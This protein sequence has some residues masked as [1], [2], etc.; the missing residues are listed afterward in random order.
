MEFWLFGEVQLRAGEQVLDVGT[1][2]QQAVLAALAVD[3][4]RPVAMETLVDRVWHDA[5]P[6]EAR[7]VLYSHL[8]R[9]RQLLRRAEAVTGTTARLDRRTS[10]YVLAVDPG[11]IDLHRFA[12]LV[13]RGG[14]QARSIEERADSLAEA[15]RLWRG[16]P[17]AGIQ[18]EWAAQVRDTWH[19]RRL[20]AAVRWASLQLELERAD[21][22][23]A[24][25]PGLV[26]E[27]PLA[28]PLEVL[29]LRALHA[30]GRDAEALDRYATVQQRLAEELGTDPGPELRTLHGALL[31]GELPVAERRERLATPA[32]LPPDVYGFAGRDEE[33]RRLD[34]VVAAGARIVAMSGTAGVGKTSLVVHWAHRVRDDFPGGQLYV[35]LRGFDPTGSPVPPAVAVRGFLDAFEVPLQR[36]PATFE[37]Q[38]GLYR[39]LLADRHVLV[40][41]DNARDAEQVRQLLPGSPT[42]V[43]LVASRNALVGLVTA[44]AHPLTVDLLT[45]DGARQL[46]VGRLGTAR[47][48]A[49]PRAVDEIIGLCARLP[50]ALAVVAARAATNP[51]FDLAALARELGDARYSLDE[52]A[53]ADPATDPRAVFSWS[54][55][56]LT[57][58]A[59]RLFRLFGLNSG[60]EIGARATASLMGL[61]PAQVRQLLAE[62]VAARLVAEPRPGRYTCHDL[63]RAYASEL[64]TAHDPETDRRAAT[65]R[66]LGH[67]VHT[68]NEAD[69]LLD[70]RR[71]PPPPLTP[72]P[73]GVTPERLTDQTR[74]R[75][76]FDAEYRVLL[77]AMRQDPEF[78]VEVWELSWMTR[79]FLAYQ[80]HWH[81][82]LDVLTVALAAAERLGD[83]IKQAFTQCYL[84]TTYVWFEKHEDARIRLETALELYRDAGHDIGQAFVHYYLAWMLERQGHNEEAL[85]HVEQSLELYRAADHL[86]GQAKALNA[87]GWFHALLGDYRTAIDYCEKT[88]ALQM[89]LG[90]QVAAGQT[91]HSLGYA[92]DHLGDHARAIACY[93]A[94]VGLFR[95]SGYLFGEALVLSSLGDAYFA[96]DDRNAAREA[97]QQSFDIFDQLGHPDAEDSRAKLTKLKE[98]GDR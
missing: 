83:R 51:T 21:E 42:C 41:L 2:R 43:V 12:G 77:V 54:Y 62:L 97:W 11:S 20:D 13:E 32:Q 31:R 60:P 70:P 45:G 26:A 73:P 8:S 90:D 36:I 92:H 84:G 81:I 9:I 86:P 58:P 47:V 33:L 3:A 75:A 67:Y 7:N 96:V 44:G 72:L 79:R 78:D 93:Q 40:V 37:A 48:A 29:F 39:S 66:L 49:E 91:W 28:E 87:V 46:L 57:E 52:F 89:K 23:L 30:A 74:A 5:P 95:E 38:V 35:N 19:R 10:G 94:A 55:L 76:W 65:R 63:L 59:A 64:A 82:E 18:G 98:K 50:L 6:V 22:V 25:L 4:G 14:D 27:Y 68:A 88:L 15:L 24:V 56:R 16:P 69:R 80:G 61:P 71:E 85:T 17:L 53:R 34:G 1:P